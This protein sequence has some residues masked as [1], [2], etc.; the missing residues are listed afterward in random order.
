MSLVRLRHSKK[1]S[2]ETLVETLKSSRDSWNPLVVHLI[3]TKLNAANYK[4]REF[5]TILTHLQH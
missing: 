3:T 1:H 5:S 2:S 4:E